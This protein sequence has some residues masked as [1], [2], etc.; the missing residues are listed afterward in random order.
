MLEKVFQALGLKEKPE[1]TYPDGYTS[2]GVSLYF[3]QAR[4]YPENPELTIP[5]LRFGTAADLKVSRT[6]FAY[7][8]KRGLEQHIRTE[9]PETGAPCYVIDNHN[10]AFFAWVEALRED[11]IQPGSTLIHIDT[12]VDES[13]AGVDAPPLSDLAAVARYTEQL[14]IYNFIGP[15][16]KAGILSYIIWIKPRA[17]AKSETQRHSSSSSIPLYEMGLE[18]LRLHALINAL[19]RTKLIIDIDLD[20]FQPFIENPAFTAHSRQVTNIESRMEE[21]ITLLKEMVKKAGVVTMATSPNFI[22]QE[23]AIE[24]TKKILSS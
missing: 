9:V 23:K 5:P 2:R 19:D 17:N 10:Y 13:W 7:Q 3:P 6:T 11:A 15:A 14:K 24:L 8:R 16:L 4:P 12:H 18:N 21:D 1:R 20:Y 22:D